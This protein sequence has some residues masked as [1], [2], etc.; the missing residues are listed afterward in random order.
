MTQSL[1][2]IR[3]RAIRLALL[4]A[5]LALAPAAGADEWMPPPAGS[6]ALTARRADGTALGPCP[7]QHTD[8]AVEV[9]GFVARAV[10]TQTFV[11]PFP[12][13]VEAVY[14][15]PLSARAAVD[16]MTM[17]TGERVI[18]SE[19]RRREDARRVYEAA[20]AAGRLATLLDQERPN[21]FSQSLANLMPG[22]EVEIR[23]AYVEPLAYADGSFELSIP[24]VVGPRFV[25]GTPTGHAGT[26]FASDT[27][28]VP[29]ASRVTPPVAPEGM[30][31]GHDLGITID[32]DAGV[33]VG[34]IVSPLHAITIE[35]PTP[36]RVRIALAR[37]REIPNRDFVL[38]WTAAGDDIRNAALTHRAPGTDGYLTLMLLPPRR[39]TAQDAA[40]KELV[41]V[42]DRS[43]SQA[44][45]PLEKAKETMRW[46][47]D[48]LNQRDTFQIVDFGA[49]AHVLFTEPQPVTAA[50]RK[51]ARDHI[52]ALEA[53]G[54]TMMAE[55]VAR[56]T[57]MPADEHRLRIVTFMTDGYVGNDLEVLELV[58]RSR[59]TS[60]WF[61]FG[62]GN[63]V[64][65]YLIEAMAR[66]GGGE[67]EM[68]L[69][70]DPGDV[71]AQRFHERLA[72]PV[73][74]D[75]QVAFEGLDVVEVEPRAF[76]DVWAERPLVIH[77]R[78]RRA[79]RGTVVLR[80]F[81]GG[82]PY[83][84]R[85]AVELPEREA[86]HAAIASLWARAR[87]DAIMDE[88]LAAAQRG[89]VPEERR[90]RLVAIALEH[91]L[92]TQFTS[93]VAI[94][95]TVV[96]ESGRQRTVTVPVEMP[97]G[98][99]YA[100]IFGSAAEAQAVAST[101]MALARRSTAATP[102][103]AA[104]NRTYEM[105]GGRAPE[106]APHATAAPRDGAAP[107][108]P[109]GVP[110]VGVR[111]RTRLAPELL[112]LATA[113]A[114]A[115]AAADGLCV[116]VTLGTSGDGPLRALAAAGLVIERTVGAT[117]IGRIA[118]AKLLALAEADGVEHIAL[119]P[120]RTLGSL[121]PTADCRRADVAAAS[122]LLANPRSVR[123]P[124]PYPI[125]ALR[126]Q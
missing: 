19:V 68:V 75:V 29:D 25:P 83:E 51:R 97:E 24:T 63:S 39:T 28:R 104:A 12:D 118:V 40:P 81:R 88:D 94:E 73:L 121:R 6:S 108:T 101:P 21:I 60:R 96:N 18:R 120:D 58:R 2:R 123:E 103:T 54:G 47:I 95:E 82:R 115:A 1:F 30:R 41:F 7:L 16:D 42:I 44:G 46:I 52:D 122:G 9:S 36:T 110:A 57:A 78:Y 105:R 89:D 119:E 48:H 114:G 126:A 92:L 37:G 93:F 72:A 106:P 62:T 90:E 69:L 45:A 77:A 59:G 13:P 43:G 98:V 87:V 38:R 35:R 86:A 11:N 56:V 113:P 50:T 31:A 8:I 124:R 67:P 14:T 23:I 55:A 10:V 26:G 112:A 20:R 27:G 99:G 66:L 3:E 109:T 4:L 70:A 102:I 76:A 5:W 33:P 107:P 71:V 64:N 116:R 80:G 85:L 15:F 91:R 65:R 34:E 84:Q 53:N 61:P 17:R 22:A 79:G 32:I 100:G 117:A 125:D 49:D 74:T 111:A